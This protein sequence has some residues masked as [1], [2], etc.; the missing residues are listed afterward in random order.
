[1]AKEEWL[2]RK[3][4]LKSTHCILWLDKIQFVLNWHFNMRM[5]SVQL[6]KC[7]FWNCRFFQRKKLF[8]W[9]ESCFYK[10]YQNT[11]FSIH[12]IALYFWGFK[13]KD[14][15][16]KLYYKWLGKMNRP[17]FYLIF[18]ESMLQI[19]HWLKIILWRVAICR[20]AGLCQITTYV[21]LS[22]I[23]GRY[24]KHLIRRPYFN[25]FRVV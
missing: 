4:I 22:A 24:W 12:P 3:I 10:W 13:K 8:Y 5:D 17:L 25:R 2:C 1:M 21:A 15:N 23:F 6:K 9:I 14:Q 20:K 19:S 11:A 18:K 16:L 7:C